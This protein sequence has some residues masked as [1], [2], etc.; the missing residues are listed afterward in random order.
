MKQNS[1]KK[2][3]SLR[4][5]STGEKAEEDIYRMQLRSSHA[6]MQGESVVERGKRGDPEAGND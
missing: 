2:P 6:R 4:K 5:L 3:V 1:S